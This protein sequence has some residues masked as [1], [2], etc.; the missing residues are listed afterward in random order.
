MSVGR[1]TFFTV[2]SRFKIADFSKGSVIQSANMKLKDSHYGELRLESGCLRFESCESISYHLKSPK[3][4][5]SHA[6]LTHK[7]IHTFIICVYSKKIEQWP[8][9]H[10]QGPTVITQPPNPSFLNHSC[11]QPN[12]MDKSNSW[13][14]NNLLP[15]FGFNAFNTLEFF[16]T[17]QA[18]GNL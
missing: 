15:P 14:F 9:Q 8:F 18:A 7:T 17:R 2:V 10:I 3:I 1:C 6:D 11:P 12:C 13:S 4:C 5:W 16:E